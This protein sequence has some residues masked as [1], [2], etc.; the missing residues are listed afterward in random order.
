MPAEDKFGMYL[1]ILTKMAMNC[2]AEQPAEELLWSWTVWIWLSLKICYPQW[3][4]GLENPCPDQN[5]GLWGI[6]I[7]YISIFRQTHMY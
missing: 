7:P 6:G 3:T 2:N 4:N 1:T 5:G